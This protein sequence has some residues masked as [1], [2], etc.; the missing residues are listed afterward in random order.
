MEL[1]NKLVFLYLAFV[2]SIALIG[3]NLRCL[4]VPSCWIAP[5]P[6]AK[7]SSNKYYEKRF[8]KT[9]TLLST[10]YI[11]GITDTINP[12]ANYGH[13]YRNRSF[14]FYSNGLVLEDE[15][16]TNNPNSD[17]IYTHTEDLKF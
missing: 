15:Y 13:K 2:F 6:T 9:D 10:H 11:Y 4:T 17:T 1:K 12:E 7:I 14:L 8:T 16:Y 3:C 5:G